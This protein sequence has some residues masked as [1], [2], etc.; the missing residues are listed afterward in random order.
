V[1]ILFAIKALD[2]RGGGA[3][4][5]LAV[6][7][8]GLAAREHDVAVVTFD[9]P[10]GKSFYPLDARVRRIALGLGATDAPTGGRDFVARARALRGVLRRERPEVAVGFMHS[11]YVAMSLAGVGLGIPLIASKHTVPEYY[12]GR[13]GQYA[14]LTL[15]LS[16]ASRI[17]V[18]SPAVRDRF[19]ARLRA[20]MVAVPNPV[21]V[22]AAK[23]PPGQAGSKILLS[24]GRLEAEKDHATLI[25]AFALLATR[26]PHWRLRIVGDGSLRS[27]LETR[28]ARACVS[29]RVSLPGYLEVAGVEDEYARADLFAVPS[30]FESF[31]MA[32]AEALAAGLPAIGFSDCPGTNEI[33]RHD[34]N[35]WLVHA[36][37]DSDR[38]R[39]F[40][41]GLAA[42]MGSDAL[43]ARL[44]AR[45]RESVARFDPASVVSRWEELLQDVI[46]RG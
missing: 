8:S 34:E 14:L 27:A 1:K 3:E 22:S 43:R 16:R 24:V 19:P 20:R 5:V 2:V 38:S 13:R 15:A 30:R 44:A 46:A 4:R 21:V 29:D 10:G 12:R 23:R 26:F 18:L 33:I 28:A 17:T 11:M 32:T 9:A 31:G 25:D 7:A 42:V 37:D 36:I 45:A 39:S 41:E 35:G 40:A 6:V